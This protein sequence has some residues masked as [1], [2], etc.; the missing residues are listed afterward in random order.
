MAQL[1][2]IDTGIL[3]ASVS[4]IGDLV[5]I[6][7]SGTID[8]DST[9]YQHYKVI[10]L[11]QFTAAEIKSFINSRMVNLDRDQYVSKYKVNID[12]TNL[13][14]TEL[15]TLKKLQVENIL[16]NLMVEKE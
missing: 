4:A 9:G 1:I 6:F 11:P 16:K 2:L 7:E 14:A 12:I 5:D 8:P 13:N 15:L 3:R 10:E